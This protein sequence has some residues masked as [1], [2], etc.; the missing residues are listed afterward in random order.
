MDGW[1]DGYKDT[2]RDRDSI[3]FVFCG[4][5]CGC[6]FAFS[7]LAFSLLFR[8]TIVLYVMICAVRRISLSLCSTPSQIAKSKRQEW[9]Q[10]SITYNIHSHT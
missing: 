2:H 7:F 3:L 5:F 1:M 6:E 9:H 8:Y 10:R 4:A